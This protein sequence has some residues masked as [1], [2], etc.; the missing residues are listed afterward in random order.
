MLKNLL[1]RLIYLDHSRSY[2]ETY[3][4]ELDRQCYAVAF[5]CAF[6]E[7]VTWL[8]YIRVDRLLHPENKL[9]PS[10]RYGLSVV[11]LVSLGIYFWPHFK[12]QG[13]VLLNLMY[14][15]LVI[16]TGVITALTKAHAPYVGGYIFVLMCAIIIPL[17][18]I[19]VYASLLTSGLLFFGI[20]A[21]EGVRFASAVEQYSL[22]DLMGVFAVVSIFVYVLDHVRFQSYQ[23]AKEVETQKALIQAANG[24]LRQEIAERQRVENALREANAMK[25]T[26]FSIIAHDLRTPF[27]ALLGNA[28]LA[29]KFFETA[30]ATELKSMIERIKTSAEA[31]YALLENLLTWSRLQR[32][33]MEY[34]PCAIPIAE[35]MTEIIQLFHAPA[36]HKHIKL[37]QQIPPSTVIWADTNMLSTVLRNLLANAL[38]FTHPGGRVDITA[39]QRAN[40]IEMMI[41]DTGIGIPEDVLPNL[42][43][44]DVK[45]MTI[46]TAGERGT[47]LGLPLC[48]DLI[49]KNGGTIMVVSLP[50]QGTTF[51]VTL[52]KGQDSFQ[53]GLIRSEG[54]TP[55]EIAATSSENEHPLADTT[56]LSAMPPQI[57]LSSQDR[58]RLVMALTRLS[59][60]YR[61]QLRNAVEGCEMATTMHIIEQIR[62]HDE[63]LAEALTTL[64]QQY[65]FDMLQELCGNIAA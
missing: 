7:V 51:V 24:Q 3:Y 43:R 55:D 57:A 32:G 23:K 20:Y 60:A 10:L 64:V 18:K 34:R 26:F 44:V 53:T 37:R 65:Q 25:D 22:N 14:G 62:Q 31:A 19:H 36:E 5:V 2:P 56:G 63:H 13:I 49:E 40:E 12:H 17:P 1:N 41:A 28:E 33:L 29:L 45:T 27:T 30:D 11:G 61:T 9:I 46:G 8:F 58:E 54:A 15:Y 6:F 48:Q 4:A 39:R 59:P 52:P 47:G 16:A 35:L 38:K 21:F 42:F 50:G